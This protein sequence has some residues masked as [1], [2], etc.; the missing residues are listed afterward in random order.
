MKEHLEVCI[1]K[2]YFD[3]TLFHDGS[4]RCLV[5]GLPRAKSGREPVQVGALGVV[6]VRIDVDHVGRSNTIEKRH[7]AS[8]SINNL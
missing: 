5:G 4:G 6:G 7:L 1:Y 8:H 3:T 2:S